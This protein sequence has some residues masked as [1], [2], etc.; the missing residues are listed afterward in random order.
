MHTTPNNLN[1]RTVKA[2]AAL[3]AAALL[4]AGATWHGLAAAPTV[5]TSTPAVL[6]QAQQTPAV[7]RAS[8]AGG[9][10]SYAD[11]VKTVAPAVVT[12]QV[13]GKA[14]VSPTQ[15]N[16]DDEDMLRRFFGDRFGQGQG[17]GQMPRAPKQRGL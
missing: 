1:Q 2:A 8:I 11:V 14:R 13:E 9:R 12:V 3:G 5:P 6:A 16:G 17:R 15:F 4:V 7:S 10:D